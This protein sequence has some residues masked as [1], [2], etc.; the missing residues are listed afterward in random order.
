[1][2]AQQWRAHAGPGG[3]QK[4]ASLALIPCMHALGL[5]AFLPLSS[6]LWGRHLGKIYERRVEPEQ[7]QL[8]NH[9]GNIL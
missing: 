1:M 9:K 5:S 4:A 6:R 7:T 8:W 2:L 3:S